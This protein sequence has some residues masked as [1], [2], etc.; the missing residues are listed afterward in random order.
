[1]GEAG[2]LDAWCDSRA[3]DT[4][5]RGVCKSRGNKHEQQPHICACG[6]LCCPNSKQTP[7]TEGITV[8]QPATNY[9]PASTAG[10]AP[11]PGC[12]RSSHQPRKPP[13]PAQTCARRFRAKRLRLQNQS[14]RTRPSKVVLAPNNT[15]Q[16]NCQHSMHSSCCAAQTRP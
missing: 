13:T 4:T 15:S 6:S 3:P 12:H 1:M 14:C 2:V 16:Q 11:R 10:L 5:C 7:T 9:M 8:M